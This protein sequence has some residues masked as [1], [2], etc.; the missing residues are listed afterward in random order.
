MKKIVFISIVIIGLTSC[1][2]DRVCTCTNADGSLSSQATY[3]KVTK[4][5]ARTYC[6][7]SAQGVTCTV[8]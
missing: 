4:K 6:T 7:S 1:K 5:E 2:K 8:K 3:T